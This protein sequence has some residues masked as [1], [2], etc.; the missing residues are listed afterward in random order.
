MATAKAYKH[1][2]MPVAGQLSLNLADAGFEEDLD[3]EA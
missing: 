3:D 2:G 1:L